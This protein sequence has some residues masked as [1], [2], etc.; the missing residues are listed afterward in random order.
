MRTIDYVTFDITAWDLLE[1]KKIEKRWKHQKFQ[2]FLSINLFMGRPDFASNLSDIP[3][4]RKQSQQA[5]APFAGIIVDI[6]TELIKEIQ[7]FRQIIKIPLASQGFSYIGSYTIPFQRMSYVIKVQCTELDT[8]GQREAFALQHL[9]EAGDIKLD[10]QDPNFNPSSITPEMEALISTTSD[11]TQLD[12][13][14][15]R[16]PLSRT[17]HYLQNIQK[18]I[19][20]DTSLQSAKP[21]KF[22]SELPDTE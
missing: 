22:Y 2:D 21:F 13:K 3:T 14:F 5:I 17:R 6:G 7:V 8:I 16:H 11:S 15:S 4:L 12:M 1:V 19:E 10:L 9:L 18:T 20:L